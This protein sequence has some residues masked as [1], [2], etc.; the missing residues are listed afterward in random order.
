MKKIGT[1]VVCLM[2]ILMGCEKEEIK[3]QTGDLYVTVYGN[4][5]K[6]IEGANIFT[7]PSTV[8]SISDEFGTALLKELEPGS[9][10]VFASSGDYGSGKTVVRIVPDSLQK[11]F[12][13]LVKGVTTGYNPEI[14]LILPALP[15]NFSLNENI[16]FSFNVKDK[17]T[18]GNELKVTLT[19]NLDGKLVETHPNALDN[20]RFETSSLSRGV[21]IITVTATDKDNYSATKTFELSTLAPGNVTMESAVAENGVV[22][23]QW[24]KYALADFKRYEVFRSTDPLEQGQVIAAFSSADSVNFIDRLPPF[25]SFVYYYVKVTN[26]DNYNRNSNKIKVEHPAGKIYYHLVTDAVHH[27]DEPVVFIIDHASQKLLSINY[28]TQVQLSSVSLQGSAG[29]I[30]IGDNGFGLEIYVPGNDGFIRIYN[31]ST[32]DYV[33]SIT[34]G[35]A[36]RCVAT[37]GN[38]Y[39]VASVMP[40][41]WWEQP[42][43]TY[44]RSTGI[45]IS[46]NPGSAFE[47]SIMRFVPGTD[48]VITISTGV[49]PTD[50]D[51]LEMDNSGKIIKLVD[52]Q[53]HGDHPLD[54]FIF[55]ISSN[56][57]YLVTGSQGAVYSAVSSMVYKGMIDRGALT[58]SDYAFSSNGRTIYAGTSN[59]K[60]IQIIQYPELVRNDEIL[61]KGYPKFLFYHKGE[62][63]SISKVG[64]HSENIAFERVRVE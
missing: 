32:L 6:P 24:Q 50:M 64:E 60:S 62:I 56:G 55:R 43:R 63:I 35:L 11:V 18:P 17:D 42:V 7:V 15:A 37:N 14:E 3:V 2:I 9:Y 22:L 46:G 26:N 13:H 21:H 40:S 48:H 61:L 27:P 8:Q 16:V 41:P 45:N 58:Y 28:E 51:Y 57:E 59:R 53:Y 12:I 25:E 4:F 54:P 10:E 49:S 34:T 19:S 36:T 47:G 38:G 31:A 33:T 29:K 39:I 1:L 44:S 5:S 23:L 20:V 52:D 30:D